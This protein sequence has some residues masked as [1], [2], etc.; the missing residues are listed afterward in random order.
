[1][2]QIKLSETE[3]YN[4]IKESVKNILSES[5]GYV[6]YQKHDSP[7]D[8]TKKGNGQTQP[9][10]DNIY[11]DRV[12]AMLSNVLIAFKHEKYED[13]KKQVLRIYKLVDAMINQS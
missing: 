13:A 11:L 7:Y 8:D 12:R 5:E 10:K 3:L 1:M 4:L 9:L 2:N 6:K